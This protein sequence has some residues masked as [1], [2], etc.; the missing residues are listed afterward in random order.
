MSETQRKFFMG[1]R[2]FYTDIITPLLVKIPLGSRLNAAL[3]AF[4]ADLRVSTAPYGQSPCNK[5]Y[6]DAEIEKIFAELDNDSIEL[7]KRFM[8]RQ[9]NM[10]AESY[11]IHPKYFYTQKERNEFKLLQSDYKKA[12]KKYKYRY[13]EVGVES[14]YYHH[15]LR[16]APDYIKN[17]IAGK[18]FGDVGGFLGDSALVF[19]NYDPGKVVIFEPM[20]SC[21]T[22]MLKILNENSISREKYDIQ[23]F[24]LSDKAEIV[25]DMQCKTLDEISMQYSKPF[26]VLKAD[27]EGMGLKFVKGAEQ[28]IKRD[29]PLLSL[30]IYH[31]A[32]EFAGIY[33]TLK[34]WNLNYH[35]EL[36]QFSPM[37]AWSELSLLAYPKEW[38]KP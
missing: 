15:G 1:L 32:D 13:D 17:N 11:F 14:L 27:I 6:T 33:Q 38:I 26:G 36:K 30:S 21:Q 37:K 28:T 18:L 3:V 31:N 29:R 9:I 10:P 8:H 19:M 20:T 23:P 7:A 25:D 24:A 34:S 12:C 16:F 35:Y 5:F 4:C 2:T 22:A